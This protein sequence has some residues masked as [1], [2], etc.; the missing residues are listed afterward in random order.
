VEVLPFE[1]LQN[2]YHMFFKKINQLSGNQLGPPPVIFT[3]KLNP[4]ISN[5]RYLY[6]KFR[7]Q[8]KLWNSAIGYTCRALGTFAPYFS[9]PFSVN[10]SASKKNAYRT[11]A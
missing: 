11:H 3:Q 4:T 5:G 8:R 1:Y 10:L 6:L 9:K 2:D 7:Q